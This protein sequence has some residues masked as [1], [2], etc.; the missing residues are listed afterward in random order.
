MAD[1]RRIAV[2]SDL[3]VEFDRAEAARRRLPGAGRG[4][5]GPDLDGLA[6]RAD[7]V[8][9]AGDIDIGED[10]V[11]YAGAVAAR[12]GLPVI[13]V[14]GNHE[15]YGGVL[16]EVRDAMRRR[17]AAGG[18]VHLLEDSAV[19]LNLG[20]RAVRFLGTTLWTDF[21]LYG[22]ARQRAD[23][24]A[25]A[26]LMSD[27]RVIEA[28][29][30]RPLKPQDTVDLHGRALAWLRRELAAPF[31]GPTVVVS[32]H[33]PSSRSVA[34]RYRDDPL[35]AAFASRLDRVVETSGA[36][37]WVHGHMHGSSDYTLGGTR[38]VCNPRGYH[39]DDLN[40]DF[41]PDMVATL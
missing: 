23:M 25:A 2:M 33:A 12:L 8:V 37:L 35:S 10:A 19:E 1:G 28:Q 32:H 6:G 26:G 17:A 36:A 3:H 30:G 41:V 27:F 24:A 13:L 18:G 34:D 4:Q 16:P 22:T 14:A 9:L 5:L 39:P 29:A 38:V 40:P 7:A 31:T 21:A 15:Y 20:G 11:D